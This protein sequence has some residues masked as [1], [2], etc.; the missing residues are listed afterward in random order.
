MNAPTTGV[1]LAAGAGTRFNGGA[2]EPKCLARFGDEPLITLQLR[3]LRACG[4]DRIAVVVGFAADEVRR[5]CGDTVEFI[6]NA[7][8][9]STNS[10]YSLWLA[11]EVLQQGFVVMNCDVLFPAVMLR[12]LVTAPVPDALLVSYRQAGDPEFGDE[13]MKVQVRD[14]RVVAIAKDL[15]LHDADGENVGIGKFNAAGARGLIV[16]M[17]DIIRSGR[18]RDWAPRAFGA[19]AQER[20]LHAVGTR[21][22]PWTEIDTVE[23]YRHALAHVFTAI[24]NVDEQLAGARAGAA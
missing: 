22:L 24:L 18:L 7:S 19:F 20:A 13:E 8:F 2:V 17:E 10:L 21:G 4:I 23:D 3:A 16:L 11:R 9:E 12:D 6:E 15:P 14:G 5:A 1:I